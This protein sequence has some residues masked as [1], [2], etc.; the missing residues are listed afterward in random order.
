MTDWATVSSVATAGGTLVLAIA[1]FGSVRSANRSTRL[2]ELA[3]QEQMRPMLVHSHLDDPLQSIRFG[4][5]HRVEA[6]GGGAVVEEAKDNI[7][8]AVSLRNVG[9]GIGVIQAW[10][11]WSDETRSDEHAALDQF[12]AQGRDFYIP[13]AGIGLWQ[14][15]LRDPSQEIYSLVAAACRQRRP[16]SLELLYTD[17]TAAQRTISRFIITPSDRSQRWTAEVVRNW[18]LDRPGPRP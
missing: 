18:H 8:L 4:D 5:G 10:F 16:F 12:R 1:T 7:Y 3:F 6:D 9:A 13:P 14:G 11:P 15:A 17:S 2:S